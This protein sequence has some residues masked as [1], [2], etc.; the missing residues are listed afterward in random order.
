MEVLHLQVL[1]VPTGVKDTV[2]W[3]LKLFKHSISQEQE[4]QAGNPL[5]IFNQCKDS[6]RWKVTAIYGTNKVLNLFLYKK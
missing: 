2:W 6:L 1:L 3:N 4:N 5:T